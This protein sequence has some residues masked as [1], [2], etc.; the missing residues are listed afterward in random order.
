MIIY[1]LNPIIYRLSL[2][3]ISFATYTVATMHDY[4]SRFDQTT[5]T[6]IRMLPAW[7][8]GVMEVVTLIGQPVIVLSVGALLAITCFLKGAERVALAV[9]I[10]FGAFGINTIIKSIVHRTRPDTLYALNMHIKS[11]SFPSGHAFGSIFFYGLLA[12]LAFQHLTHPWNVIT[13][14]ALAFLILLIGVS[15]V[16]LGAHFPSDVVAGWLFGAICLLFVIK[17]TKL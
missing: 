2:V 6:L 9:C 15:R 4:V 17:I 5:A 1:L 13:A 10:G 11:Y 12:Y 16:Y 14:G 8:N 3:R 7:A